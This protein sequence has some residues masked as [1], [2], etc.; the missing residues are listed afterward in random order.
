VAAAALAVSIARA[1][2]AR[3]A[4]P[5]RV[6]G[7]VLFAAAFLFY[8]VLGMRI[9]GPAGPQGDEPHYLVMAQ[10]LLS[11][12][13]LDLRDE[14]AHREYSGFFAGTLQPHTSRAA[15]RA[16]LS[17]HARAWPSCCCHAYALGGY[18]G[19]RSLHVA[20]AALTAVLVHRL[21][22]DVS[23]H[24][25]AATLA[26]A[27]VAF[28]P[29]L[30]FY[31]VALYPEVPAAL[32]TAAFLIL[33]RRD[34]DGAARSCPRSWLRPAVDPSPAAAAGRGRARPHARPPVPVDGAGLGGGGLRG[35]RR[36]AP[37]LLRS[38][39]GEP[40]Y[41]PRMVPGSRPT[42]RRPAPLGRRH[43]SWTGSSVSSRSRRSSSWPWPAARRSR[44]GG[45]RRPAR[46]AAGGRHLPHG[47]RR[48]ACGG[49]ARASGAIR[50]AALPALALAL[51]PALARGATPARPWP[52]SAWPS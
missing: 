14:F 36:A 51:A 52:A 23:I 22:R 2:A 19:A 6:R 33:A 37:L 5:A 27:I 43:C 20:L 8:A 11:D 18:V 44:D 46:G 12:G 25:S 39:Y 10:S 15:R 9:P 26:W 29:P 41:R 16:D 47:G 7:G 30:A 49:A 3:E 38:L 1:A 40:R 24:P 50:G 45:G 28:T 32:A 13:D 34:P 42:S 4:A 48:S 35:L 17:H 21:V 31:A